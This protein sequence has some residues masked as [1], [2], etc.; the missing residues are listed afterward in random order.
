MSDPLDLLDPSA[1]RAFELRLYR[2]ISP[3]VP[4]SLG[5]VRLPE[6]THDIADTLGRF[7]TTGTLDPMYMCMRGLVATVLP[8]CLADLV[9]RYV[10]GYTRCQTIATINDLP[11]KA[12]MSNLSK[13][14]M[15]WLHAVTPTVAYVV[16]SQATWEH[17]SYDFPIQN[18]PRLYR[19]M[20]TTREK[21]IVGT[22]REKQIVILAFP[23]IAVIIEGRVL[24][25]DV[26]RVEVTRRII[27]PHNYRM[28]GHIATN[29]KRTHLFWTALF[30]TATC[31]KIYVL[32]LRLPEP[33]DPFT[34]ARCSGVT[35]IYPF[36]ENRI[37]TLHA[38]VVSVWCY[39]DRT[40]THLHTITG[41]L[42][43]EYGA[44]IRSL[45]VIRGETG[46]RIVITSARGHI[47]MWDDTGTRIQ[48]IL[49]RQY[50]RVLGETSLGGAKGG[51]AVVYDADCENGCVELFA[52]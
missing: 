5:S 1:L 31:R 46:F 32:D 24:I 9:T 48:T 44:S 2:D 38:T 22:T 8:R 45:G 16:A 33:C 10:I 43:G 28:T 52:C 6:N 17:P 34:S 36:G 19:L 29:T 41:L 26:V 51:F 30:W 14:C 18:L 3:L 25:I 40:I 4:R 49:R 15:M 39:V 21:Q 12:E 47:C 23:L 7:Q 20:G 13:L 35:A 11:P 50:A 37:A 27:D 42:D